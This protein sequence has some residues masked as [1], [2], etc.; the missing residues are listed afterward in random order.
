MTRRERHRLDYYDAVWRPHGIED[1]LRL[2]LPAPPGRARSI[3]LERSGRNYTDRDKTLLTLLRPQLIRIQAA[4]ETRR[5][6]NRLP[7]LTEREAEVLAY[8]AGG[9]TNHEIAKMLC[10]SP[11][12]V[13]E[14]L[15]SIFEKLGVHTRTAAAAQLAAAARPA[16]DDPAT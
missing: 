1:A 9:S 10:I 5:R 11:H 6:A 13:R 7:N 8:V 3:Y 2:W 16:S 15:E 4:R 14:H 12:T